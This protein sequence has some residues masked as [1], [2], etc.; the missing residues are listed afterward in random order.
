MPDSPTR[1]ALEELLDYFEQLETRTRA[2]LLLLKDKGVIKSDEELKPYLDQASTPTDVISR[3]I[4]ARFDSLFS[5]D[6]AKPSTGAIPAASATNSNVTQA[7]V[8]QPADSA[9][10]DRNRAA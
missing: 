5:Q 2:I 8:L 9:D 7:A 1:E 3:A 10:T 4:H 6:E